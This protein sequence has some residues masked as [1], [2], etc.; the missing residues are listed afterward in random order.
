VVYCDIFIPSWP[1]DLEQSTINHV[2]GDGRI[3]DEFR[4]TFTHDRPME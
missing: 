1:G 3:V 2:A 4:T